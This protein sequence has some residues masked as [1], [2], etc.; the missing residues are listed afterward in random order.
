MAMVVARLNL[1]ES[2]GQKLDVQDPGFLASLAR[3]ARAAAETASQEKRQV[4]A[5]AA[6]HSGPWSDVEQERR[7]EFVQLACELQPVHIRL[8]VFLDAPYGADQVPAEPFAD[9]MWRWMMHV[10][11]LP[12]EDLSRVLETLRARG[13]AQPP[14]GEM[15]ATYSFGHEFLKFLRG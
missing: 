10:L 8:L 11:K 15:R 5:R 2:G 14:G 6:A 9:H 3:A 13:L 1:I 12:S 7:E 4:L